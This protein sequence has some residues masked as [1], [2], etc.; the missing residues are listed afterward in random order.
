MGDVYKL[1]IINS[2]LLGNYLGVCENL[3]NVSKGLAELLSPY[4]SNHFPVVLLSSAI[5]QPRAGLLSSPAL[6][7]GRCLAAWPTFGS[8]LSLGSL[9][10]A[11]S[12]QG[13]GDRSRARPPRDH[14][15]GQK[16]DQRPQKSKVL[17]DDLGVGFL[18]LGH[19]VALAQIPQSFPLTFCRRKKKKV[20]KEK[21]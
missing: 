19:L 15:Q 4:T 13:A 17:C 9:W 6:P 18:M 3:E 5:G 1:Q 7:P 21:C 8:C 12:G 14:S 10:V 2:S 20:R 16:L 11:G